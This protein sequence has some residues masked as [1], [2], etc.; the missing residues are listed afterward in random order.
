MDLLLWRHAEAEPGQPDEGRRLTRNG[1]HQARLMAGWLHAHLSGKPRILVSPS[2]RTRQTAAPFSE[3][4]EVAA[5]VG[6]EANADA[7][8]AATG[9]PDA[10]GTV[11]VVG[12]QPTLGVVAARLLGIEDESSLPVKKGAIWWFQSRVREGTREVVLKAVIPTSLV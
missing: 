4:Y 9:W 3:D 11:V 1:E 6:T 10:G 5:D 8:L 2:E 12:H 7:L